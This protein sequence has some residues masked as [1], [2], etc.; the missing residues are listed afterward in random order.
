MPPRF[1]VLAAAV[2]CA[3]FTTAAAQTVRLKPFRPDAPAAAE[4]ASLAGTW[5]G[6][7]VLPRVTGGGK[8]E[9]TYQV[10]VAPR[11]DTLRVIALPPLSSNPDPYFNPIT[12][13][14]VPA[15]WD[16]E[17]LKAEARQTA[18]DGNT[19]ITVL[20]V[21]TLRRGVD[22]RHARFRYEVRIKSTKP[23]DERTN[24]LRGEGILTRAQ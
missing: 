1:L 5:K 7:F 14:A 20:K 2:L 21:L 9:V 22:A 13:S 11:L 24:I 10:E 15:D 4:T 18:Q 16:G 6:T 23:H 19:D 17:T 12:A 3:A 8:E